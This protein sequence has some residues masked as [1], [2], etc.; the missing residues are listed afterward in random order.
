MVRVSSQ[1]YKQLHVSN[2]V[3]GNTSEVTTEQLK[4]SDH[5]LPQNATYDPHIDV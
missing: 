2:E 1:K 3:I 5:V 4:L